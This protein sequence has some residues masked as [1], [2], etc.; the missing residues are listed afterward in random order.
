VKDRT[1]LLQ[2]QCH[3]DGNGDCPK[4]ARGDE[5][6]N[7]FRRVVQKQSNAVAALDAERADR[8]GHSQSRQTQLA[9]RD[10]PAAEVDRR[11]GIIMS[12]NSFEQNH[13]ESYTPVRP[14]R[15]PGVLFG[16]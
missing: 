9:I 7:K 5:G 14:T 11:R 2:P 12:K 1:L 16:R 3:V 10:L 13:R 15:S 8:M 6:C 4:R